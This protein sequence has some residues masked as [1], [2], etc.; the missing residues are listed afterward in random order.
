MA[1][2]WE[3]W[4]AVWLQFQLPKADILAE[5]QRYVDPARDVPDA[6]TALAGARDI[7]AESVSDDA[8]IRK[9]LRSL[10][11]REGLIV[12]R[13]AKCIPHVL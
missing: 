11:A 9:T 8:S 13:Q 1:I 5:A 10:L 4:G 2:L 3:Y 6:E 12:S 7:I